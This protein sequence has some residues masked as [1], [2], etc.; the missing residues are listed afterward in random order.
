MH[1]SKYYCTSSCFEIVESK[2][3]YWVICAFIHV[4]S[5]MTMVFERVCWNEQSLLMEKPL[6]LLSV[7]NKHVMFG[8]RSPT[9]IALHTLLILVMHLLKESMVKCSFGS[10]TRSTRQFSNQKIH[11][12]IERGN[13][14]LCVNLWCSEPCLRLYSYISN[15]IHNQLLVDYMSLAH[16]SF[17][18]II[19]CMKSRINQV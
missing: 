6:S 8:M 16:W 15:D 18:M 1:S 19:K 9:M 12:P 14:F 11:R 3:F 17:Q 13:T 4:S 2:H 5:L 10:W 7:N